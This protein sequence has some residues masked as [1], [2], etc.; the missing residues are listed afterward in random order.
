MRF[1]ALKTFKMREGHCRVHATHI[2]GDLKLGL[3]VSTQRRKK[4]TMSDERIQ[5]LSDI[6]FVWKAAGR[7]KIS[8][9]P[10]LIDRHD[11]SMP[12]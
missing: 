11:A 8:L 1:A 12:A 6:G 3:W 10:G 2:E 4:S 9:R 5:R 7:A